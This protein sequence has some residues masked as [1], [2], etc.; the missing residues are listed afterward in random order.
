MNIG[1][2]YLDSHDQSGAGIG[3]PSNSY[4]LGFN[5]H[6]G[7]FRQSITGSYVGS[8]GTKSNQVNGYF[9]VNTSLNYD[10]N[11]QTSLFLT[12]NNL[13]DKEFESYKGY[14]ADGRSFMF[15]VKKTL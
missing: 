1:Y 7:N 4:H 5:M 15:G 9:S 10:L 8:T 12:I 14:P 13:F 11:T 2:T 6:Q 3:D